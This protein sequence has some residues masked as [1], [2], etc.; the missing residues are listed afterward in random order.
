MSFMAD[1][2]TNHQIFISRLTEIVL[3]NLRNDNFSVKKLAR[4]VNMSHY[5]LSRKLYLITGKKVNQ[6]INEVRLKKALELLQSEDTTASEVAYNLGFSSP[7][8]FNKC[9]HEY[10]GYP[11]G[12]VI[13][14]EFVAPDNK[15]EGS[16]Y[17]ESILARNILKRYLLTFPGILLTLVVLLMI[18]FLVFKKIKTTPD[19]TDNK[20][21]IAVLPFQNRTN[22]TIWDV[23]EEGI[24]ESLISWLSNSKELK[25]TRKETIYT[26]LKTQS[27]SEYASVTPS[28]AAKLSNKLDASMFIYGSIIEAG[29]RIMLN[30]ELI[31]TKTQEVLKSFEITTPVKGEINFEIIDSLRKKVTDF[32]LVSELIT[33]N[34]W[35]KHFPLVSTDSPEAL[36]YYIYGYRAYYKADWATARTWSVS[37]THL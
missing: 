10:F 17:P 19:L 31:S 2:L 25:I 21:T 32:L 27:T 33:E 12:K 14:T 7:S 3:G 16:K 35:L 29:T 24:Q 11:P 34:P 28:L 26:L 22:D 20:I 36:K 1:P 4:E 5:G 18:G 9:F 23:W 15:V 37:Y 8:Y 13:R 30:A 6:F